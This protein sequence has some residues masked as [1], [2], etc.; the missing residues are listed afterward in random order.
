MSLLSELAQ[1][2]ASM[3]SPFHFPT[4]AQPHRPRSVQPG[5]IAVHPARKGLLWAVLCG[6]GQVSRLSGH[7][8]F[9][10]SVRALRVTTPTTR[11]GL[12]TWLDLDRKVLEQL[13]KR[14]TQHN[15]L[16]FA[17]R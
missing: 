10:T 7:V 1:G 9:F 8:E 12:K 13:P 14:K 11:S 16:S 6:Q 5:C 15:Q 2:R 4:P 3:T 17:V